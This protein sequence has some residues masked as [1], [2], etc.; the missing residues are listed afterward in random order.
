MGMPWRLSDLVWPGKKKSWEVCSA[1]AGFSEA[2]FTWAV[3]HTGLHSLLPSALQ[4]L[5]R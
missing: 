5:S 2:A 4:E 3:L 1:T